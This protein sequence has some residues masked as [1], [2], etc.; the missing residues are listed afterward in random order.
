MYH[1]V[2]IVIISCL[3]LGCGKSMQDRANQWGNQ[4]NT[5]ASPVIECVA[6]QRGSAQR[7]TKCSACQKTSPDS[8]SKSTRPFQINRQQPYLKSPISDKRKDKHLRILEKQ[9]K[10]NVFSLIEDNQSSQGDSKYEMNSTENSYFYKSFIQRHDL[11]SK[12]T[13]E[14]KPMVSEEA[15]EKEPKTT[16]DNTK[17]EKSLNDGNEKQESAVKERI[18]EKK[19]YLSKIK[20]TENFLTESQLE[21]IWVESGSFLMGSPVTEKG[22]KQDEKQV[23]VT[24]S[25]GFY[26]GK[27]EVTQ[28]QYEAVMKGNNHK[29]NSSP[30]SFKKNNHALPVECVSFNDIQVFLSRLNA[31][32]FEQLP[33]GWAFTLPT[34]A[35]WEYACR[36]GTTTA[37]SWGNTISTKNANYS[38]SGY[39][40]TCPIG[41]YPANPWGFH[42]MH[43]NVFEWCNDRT[44]QPYKKNLVTDPFEIDIQGSPVLRGGSWVDGGVGSGQRMSR[45]PQLKG[46]YIGF[47]VALKQVD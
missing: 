31:R 44:M 24:V 42:D 28:Q 20:K 32:E 33:V 2:V 7:S 17:Q 27:Y 39:S 30:S 15:A 5:T 46:D 14:T 6:C 11:A 34:E 29:L 3:L 1:I 40:Q 21:M 41:Q 43:G 19:A 10:D 22:R 13:G 4:K 37:Y 9:T 35:Q 25:K 8:T 38:K 12:R 16:K 47:R 36:A 18:S 23:P 26:L 45:N